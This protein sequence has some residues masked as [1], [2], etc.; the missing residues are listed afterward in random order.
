[1]LTGI[2]HN[3]ERKQIPTHQSG[4]PLAVH[5]SELYSCFMPHIC[6]VHGAR[7]PQAESLLRSNRLRPHVC[8][9]IQTDGRVALLARAA[10]PRTWFASHEFRTFTRTSIKFGNKTCACLQLDLDG[11]VEPFHRHA[12][13]RIPVYVVPQGVWLR[14]L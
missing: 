8:P 3:V 7:H 12:A 4:P 1:M 11:G 6:L 5:H 14:D 2:V 13:Q 9:R 10:T